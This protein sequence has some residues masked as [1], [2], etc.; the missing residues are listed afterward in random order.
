MK[1]YGISMDETVMQTFDG[2]IGDVPRSAYIRRMILDE[3][4]LLALCTPSS[5]LQPHNK[6]VVNNK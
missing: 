2:V 6:G 4:E 1:R 5:Q 3:I